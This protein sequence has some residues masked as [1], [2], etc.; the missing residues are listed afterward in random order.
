MGLAPG[1]SRIAQPGAS[2]ILSGILETQ[3]QGVIAAYAE[4]GMPLL[5]R[6]Q[7]KEWTTLILHKL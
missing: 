1:M 7:R 4:N 2:I 6:L 3:A 5:Q